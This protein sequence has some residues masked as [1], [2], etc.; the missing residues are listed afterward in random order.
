MA[1]DRTRFAAYPSAVVYSKPNTTATKN[2][3]QHL[4][5]GDW[6]SLKDGVQGHWREV[7][8]RNVDG[9]MD[10]RDITE[11]RL[12]EVNFVDIGQGDGCLV[13]TPEDKWLV[14]DAGERDNMYRF[15]RWRF[16]RFQ[17]EIAFE[18]FFITH[19]DK[20][21]YYGF[22]ALLEHE[23]V[24]VGT[25]YHNGLV[26]RK[27]TDV[28]G[29]MKW[30]ENGV[31]YL[32]D[33]VTTKTRLR[34]ILDQ[35]KRNNSRKLY[36]NL[37][38][39]AVEGGR[40]DEVRALSWLDKFVPGYGPDKDL[41]LKV[42]GPVPEEGSDGK[43]RLRKL[44]DTGVT[45]NG[46]SIVLR[47][48]YK[49]VS[50]LLGGDLN[51]PAENY[52]LEH[53]TGKNPTAARGRAL[54]ELIGEARK[55]FGTDVAKACHHGSSDFSETFLKAVHPL[56]TVISSGDGESHA[57]PR[58]DAL[59]S[60]GLHGRGV[61]PLIFSTEL[62]RSSREIIKN[63]YRLRR[64]IEEL[65]S[66][67]ETTTSS[68]IRKR[69][70][71]QLKEILDNVLQRS[72]ATYGMITMRTDGKRVVMAQ[73]LEKPRSKKSKWDIHRLVPNGSEGLAYESK[74]STH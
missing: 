46:H 6:I 52:L 33:I 13:V 59:G 53:Y 9:W 62:A 54:K 60:F 19:P 34:K 61:R 73:R 68:A 7:R 65:E 70:K 67:I 14:I 10:V 36:S 2:A 64:E 27:A 40:V 31:T 25:L 74:H 50:V 63:P 22:K 44:G 11:E 18:S 4:L 55:V 16:G 51:I 28:L 35:E 30:K 39:I 17:K 20:D 48:Q 26:E 72:V 24:R 1:D 38:R 15:L 12:L 42:L 29:P 57:H 56:A 32:D 49:D 41:Q 5:W 45:K 47:L 8:A 58:P 71:K 23:K 43:W 3:V 37:L 66:K 21:H 69:S